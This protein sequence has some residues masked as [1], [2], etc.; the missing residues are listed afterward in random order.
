MSHDAKTMPNKNNK[1]NTKQSRGWDMFNNVR[2]K[3]KWNIV[4]FI[5]DK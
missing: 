1:A 2:G 4:W 5:G 3:V